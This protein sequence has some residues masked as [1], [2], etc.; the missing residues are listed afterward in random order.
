M[1]VEHGFAAELW[2]P[3]LERAAGQYADL[4][5]LHV[6]GTLGMGRAPHSTA[7]MIRGAALSGSLQKLQLVAGSYPQPVAWP[8]DISD[9]AVRGGSLEMVQFL[10][11]NQA[12]VFDVATAMSRA[13]EL[14]R[15]DML[16]FLRAAG[17]E[18][19]ISLPE[20]AA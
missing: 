7:N 2:N 4:E 16:Q 3:R 9:Y 12:A 5:T 17:A 1:A 15:L 13:V 8:E 6:A 20:T 10:A 11:L 14:G 18:L 19:D